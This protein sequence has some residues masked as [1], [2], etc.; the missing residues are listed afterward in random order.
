M[1]DKE[2]P[3]ISV[4]ILK[5]A[6]DQSVLVIKETKKDHL[7]QLSNKLWAIRANTFKIGI[8]VVA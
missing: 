6:T 2:I 8:V 7:G 1:E 5:N 4:P 3:M